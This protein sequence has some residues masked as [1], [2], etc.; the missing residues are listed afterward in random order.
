MCITCMC[1]C[2]GK[3]QQGLVEGV[4]NEHARH[5]YCNFNKMFSEIQFIPRAIGTSDGKDQISQSRCIPLFD[6][7]RAS[8]M[9]FSKP[10]K[11]V[12]LVEHVTKPINHYSS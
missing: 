12:M 11:Y 10:V 4:K 9:P 2:I 5:I 1:M 8:Y 3:K 7:E 6:E